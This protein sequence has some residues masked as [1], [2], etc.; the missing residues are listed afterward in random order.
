M[1]PGPYTHASGPVHPWTR[2][3]APM[4]LG[5]YTHEPGPTHPCIRARDPCTRARTPMHPCLYTLVHACIRPRKRTISQ[6]RIIS[7]CLLFARSRA[8][9][10]FYFFFPPSLFLVCPELSYFHLFVH[11]SWSLK[12]LVTLSPYNLRLISVFFPR[13]FSTICPEFYRNLTKT[14][15]QTHTQTHT[16]TQWRR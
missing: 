1:H 7:G 5:P 16:Q 13:L 3:R 12:F 11:P 10:S 6:K 9:L 8:F 4:H 15:R 14:D 2:A